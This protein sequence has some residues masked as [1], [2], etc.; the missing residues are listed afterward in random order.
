[1]SSGLCG[2]TSQ[3][4]CYGRCAHKYELGKKMKRAPHWEVEQDAVASDS[5]PFAGFWKTEESYPFGMAIG[6]Y[7][8]VMYYVSFCGPGGC[9]AKGEYRPITSLTNDPEYRIID[10]N[11]IEIHSKTGCTKYFRSRGRESTEA[12]ESV[13]PTPTR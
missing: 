13:E 8:D 4:R 9:F 2:I 3:N 12:S 11:T 5:H 7:G 1:M 6:P 10:T